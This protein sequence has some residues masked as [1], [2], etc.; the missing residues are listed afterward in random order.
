MYLII[1]RTKGQLLCLAKH[2]ST[3]NRELASTTRVATGVSSTCPSVRIYKNFHRN[4]VENLV[5]TT[6]SK[7]LMH[8]IA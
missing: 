3:V 1:L 7:L 4:N 5:C 2:W 6:Y 8:E